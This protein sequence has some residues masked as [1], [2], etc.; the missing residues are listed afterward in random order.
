MVR[1]AAVVGAGLSGLT[2][3]YRL[4]QAGWHVDVFES[5]DVVGGRVQT[6]RSHGYAIDTGASA[7]GSTY[8]SYIALA[9]ELGLELRPT[10][11]YIGIRRSGTTHFL[12]MRHAV[13]S[14]VTTQL[15]SRGAKMRVPRLAVDVALA[16]ARG[17]LDYSDM[18][19]A[20]PLDTQSVRD[21]AVRVLNAEVDSYLCEPIV[22]TMLIADTDKV[23][24]VELFSGIANIF[25]AKVLS[26]VG[27][28]GRVPETLAER[29]DVRLR[30]PVTEVRRTPR[31]VEVTCQG[32]TSVYDGC[33]VSCPLP[34]AFDICV[35]DREALGPL[36][37][38]LGYT[39]CVSV[40]VGTSR[41]PDCPAGTVLFPS[42]EDADIALMFLDHNKARDRAPSGHGLLSCLWE[43]GAS[44]RSIDAPD[45][46]LVERTLATVF[47]VFPELRGT[48]DFTHVTR[49][50]QALPLTR[51]GAYQ[52]IGRLDAA[53]DRRSL[54]QYAAD[55][56]SAAGQNT[57]VEFGGRA[58]S[59]L[60]AQ[61]V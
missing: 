20:A 7:L 26:V 18:G 31:G 59:N 2:A 13:R 57:A 17:W 38:V 48:V 27:G 43:A 12:D 61:A 10:A 25:A 6:V 1:R 19:K 51:I 58:A 34:Q 32:T 40:A 50:R 22:R 60:I 21:Y 35:D 24:K 30:A 52:E 4:Q 55:F 56:M 49:W 29:L 42:V 28:Q 5:G 37:S 14:G 11:P 23:S 3:G 8:R 33:V 44:E 16:K 47:E 36:R 15:L 45:D 39:Q 53:L 54:V 41:P 46:A 9:T